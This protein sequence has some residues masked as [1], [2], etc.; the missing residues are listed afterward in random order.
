MS[1]LTSTLNAMDEIDLR[2][3]AQTLGTS[4]RTARCRPLT[5]IRPRITCSLPPQW[6][7]GGIARI[8]P[9]NLFVF[10]WTGTRMNQ[11]GIR[12]RGVHRLSV[13]SVLSVVKKRV[14]ELRVLE[15]A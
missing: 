15:R 1:R 2:M 4:Q 12:G 5:P 8:N 14:H 11:G 10:P 13:L 3:I 9:S 6:V 7:S